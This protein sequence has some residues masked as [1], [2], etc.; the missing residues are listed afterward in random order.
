MSAPG[1][2]L[3]AFLKKQ[4]QEAEAK[5]QKGTPKLG[6]GAKDVKEKDKTKDSKSDET[7]KKHKT[8]TLSLKSPKQLIEKLAKNDDD[9]RSKF[10]L[11]YQ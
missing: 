1:P 5:L 6:D 3:G 2:G 11:P 4:A 9:V 7:S 8:A 10:S